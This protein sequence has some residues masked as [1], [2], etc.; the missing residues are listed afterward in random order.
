MDYKTSS[1]ALIEILNMA[2]S[3][4]ITATHNVF[5]NE[6]EPHL[7]ISKHQK[8]QVWFG[9]AYFRL[10]RINSFKLGLI[11]IATGQTINKFHLLCRPIF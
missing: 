4:N 3:I 2:Q 11:C 7:N 1:H 8:K 9:P 6:R 5:E 10:T